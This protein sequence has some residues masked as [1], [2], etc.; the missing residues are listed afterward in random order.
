[1]KEAERYVEYE[2]ID[3]LLRDLDLTNEDLAK[4]GKHIN[5]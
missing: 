5:S 4:A 2:S 3:E 1:M